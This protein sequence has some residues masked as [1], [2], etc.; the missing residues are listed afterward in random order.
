MVFG[1]GEQKRLCVTVLES[2]LSGNEVFELSKLNRR[3]P[4][5]AR[6]RVWAGTSVYVCSKHQSTFCHQVRDRSNGQISSWTNNSF[7]KIVKQKMF[8]NVSTCDFVKTWKTQ[9]CD[10]SESADFSLSH[11]TVQ[12][13]QWLWL[14]DYTPLR[15]FT[16]CTLNVRMVS[17]M[18]DFL[19][20]DTSVN[21]VLIKLWMPFN[22]H[23]ARRMKLFIETCFD[24]N[25]ALLTLMKISSAYSRFSSKNVNFRWAKKITPRRQPNMKSW[26]T[27]KCQPKKIWKIYVS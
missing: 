6:S 23:I 16:L 3:F 18:I 25:R 5:L 1:W 21:R 4:P 14:M 15:W 26:F 27:G 19:S 20:S 9:L 2:L 24:S 13:K 10:E 17:S 8:S 7:E 22:L 12:I 11:R